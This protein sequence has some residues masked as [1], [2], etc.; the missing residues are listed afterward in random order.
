MQFAA[1][2]AINWTEQ[3]YVPDGVIRAAIRRLLRA[4]LAELNAA[5]AAQVADTTGRFVAAMN[6]APIAP[7]PQKANAQHYEL[8]PAFFA[9]VTMPRLPA[10]RIP[11]GRSTSVAVSLPSAASSGSATTPGPPGP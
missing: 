8:P 5:D 4:R 11:T 9:S 6:E 10:P 7:L 2:Q 3:G 1:R